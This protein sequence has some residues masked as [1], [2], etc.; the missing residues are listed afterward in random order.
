MSRRDCLCPLGV[1]ECE[2]RVLSTE[3]LVLDPRNASGFS[4]LV[5]FWTLS[6]EVDVAACADGSGGALTVDCLAR[7][8]EEVRDLIAGSVKLAM[9]LLVLSRAN[10]AKVNSPVRFA[11]VE[12]IDCR[13][14]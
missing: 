14:L 12:P 11:L 4:G 6:V 9:A 3:K 1:D 13:F 7:L 10:A 8:L 5:V 2:R